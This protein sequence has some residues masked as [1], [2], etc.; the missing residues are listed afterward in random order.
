MLFHTYFGDY[1]YDSNEVRN[2]IAQT[3]PL[4]GAPSFTEDCAP[5]TW[6]GTR[7]A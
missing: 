6:Y 5:N 7:G 3:L 2:G 1:P 4:W